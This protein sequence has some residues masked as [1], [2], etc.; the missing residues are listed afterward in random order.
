MSVG[1]ADAATQ[2]NTAASWESREA[3]KYEAG[4]RA[5]FLNVSEGR[6]QS[7]HSLASRS[8]LQCHWLLSKAFSIVC[9]VA[10]I[11]AENWT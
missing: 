10:Q 6:N 1:I 2:R 3:C 9:N 7:Y 4:Q 11:I 5:E 8:I